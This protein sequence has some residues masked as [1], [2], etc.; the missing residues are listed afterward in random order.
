MRGAAHAA[1]LGV[2]VECVLPGA[3]TYT[4][5]AR[6]LVC[7][8]GNGPNARV[9]WSRRVRRR[10][11]LLHFLALHFFIQT[12]VQARRGSP[13]PLSLSLGSLG[14]RQARWRRPA[15]RSIASHSD[16]AASRK[17]SDTTKIRNQFLNKDV[18]ALISQI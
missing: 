12:P 3:R 16:G 14:A 10:C 15:I 9:R 5:W 13:W 1:V 2:C 6:R 17:Q 7:M 11:P 18:D 4:A 8:Y